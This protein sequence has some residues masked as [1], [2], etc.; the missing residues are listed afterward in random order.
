MHPTIKNILAGLFSGVLT[1][2]FVLGIGGRLVMRGIAIMAGGSG[3]FS[4]GGSLEVVALGAIIGLCSGAF[5]GFSLPYAMR[6]ARIWGLLQ[7]FLAYLMVLVLPI[8]GKGAALG[9]P[10]FEVTIHILFG[11]LFLIYGLAA[12]L[13]ILKLREHG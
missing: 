5:M 2:A 7:G 13:L 6:N 3:S 1:G 12:A 9:F 10:Q 4:W 11:G 8:G